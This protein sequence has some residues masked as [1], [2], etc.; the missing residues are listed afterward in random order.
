MDLKISETWSW[1]F[2]KNTISLYK[3]SFMK[4]SSKPSTSKL[5]A[6]RKKISEAVPE[7]N[8]TV[9]IEGLFNDGVA[10]EGINTDWTIHA[11]KN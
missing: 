3:V 11:S 1:R 6:R 8:V 4:S 7:G 5:I 9:K 2:L 10:F